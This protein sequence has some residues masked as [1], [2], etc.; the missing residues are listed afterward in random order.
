MLCVDEKSQIQ[1]LDRSQPVLPMRPGQAERHTHD[2]YRHGT[3]T[4]FA[5]LNYLN[6]KII[7]QRAPRHRHQE[8]LAFLKQLEA[9]HISIIEIS[10]H[11]Q[12]SACVDEH[13]MK[14]FDV[15]PTLEPTL[16]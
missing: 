15:V 9:G 1:A 2:Y 14:A 5:A 3:I 16:P 7:A 10:R 4:L 11:A 6:G 13:L 12:V 8:W